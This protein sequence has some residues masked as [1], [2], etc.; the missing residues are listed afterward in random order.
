MGTNER[1]QREKDERKRSII[2]AAREL[3][4]TEGVHATTMA[5]IA[6]RAE[7]S[8]GAVYYY[9]PSKHEL[10]GEL[11]LARLHVVRDDFRETLDEIDTPGE[12]MSALGG[13]FLRFVLNTVHS[14]RTSYLLLGEF[15]ASEIT[16]ELKDNLSQALEE[17]FSYV[18]Q[19]F[20][21][22]VE[23]GLFRSDIDPEKVG[24]AIWGAAIGIHALNTK[25]SPQILPDMTEDIYG[26]ILKWIPGGLRK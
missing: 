20:D 1:R 22:G 14:S 5:H 4:E 8:K 2:E 10:L 16:E 6:K 21:A 17:I 19:G 7:L 26:E 18:R 23:Q 24:L 13:T 12:K 25:L 11:L 3:F 15:D 9:F